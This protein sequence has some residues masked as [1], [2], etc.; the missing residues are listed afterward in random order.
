MNSLLYHEIF[1]LFNKTE[2]RA[3]KIINNIGI[4]EKRYVDKDTT[5]SDLCFKA[6]DKL[7]NEMK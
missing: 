4:K 7:L 5:A 1:E 2:K 3:D 6:A